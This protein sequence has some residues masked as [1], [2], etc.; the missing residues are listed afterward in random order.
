MIVTYE[1]FEDLDAFFGM[2]GGV[3]PH[4]DLDVVTWKYNKPDGKHIKA[5]WASLT[6]EEKEERLSHLY[7]RH[8]SEETRA[9][10]SKSMAG[11]KKPSL[12]KGGTLVKNGNVVE[13]TCLSHFCKENGLSSGHVCELLQGKRKTVKGWKLWAH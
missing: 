1:S 4:T 9:K 6:S 13:F 8:C 7:G 2:V 3:Y 10:M 12:H 5:Y 11:L